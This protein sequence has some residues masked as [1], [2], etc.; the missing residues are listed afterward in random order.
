MMVPYFILPE[1][2]G[3]YYMTN[4]HA[5]AANPSI[6]DIVLSKLDKQLNVVWNKQFDS[7]LQL[8]VTAIEVDKSGNLYM[9]FYTRGV[10]TTKVVGTVVMKI[11]PE[12]NIEWEH[13]L[14]VSDYTSPYAIQIIDDTLLRVNGGIYPGPGE[15]CLLIHS[16]ALSEIICDEKDFTPF[17][18]IADI[19][20]AIIYEAYDQF[21]FTAIM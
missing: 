7:E 15:G 11:D 9:L 13:V 6:A 17:V 14:E 5:S 21:E 18:K 19:T 2:Y 4:Q 20:S 10:L 16:N 1:P 8:T 3:G 12:G